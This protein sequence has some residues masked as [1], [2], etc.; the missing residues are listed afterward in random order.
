MQYF[1]EKCQMLVQGK[2]EVAADDRG[3]IAVVKDGNT[4]I[5]LAMVLSAEDLHEEVKEFPIPFVHW[6]RLQFW[7]TR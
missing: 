6:L 4:V 2:M 3:H 5:H 1:L 7:P